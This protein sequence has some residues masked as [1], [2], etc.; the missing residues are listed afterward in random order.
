MQHHQTCRRSLEVYSDVSNKNTLHDGGS[1]KKGSA[2]AAA[3]NVM[4]YGTVRAEGGE[5]RHISAFYHFYTRVK[6]FGDSR[7]YV[8]FWS[9]LLNT[10]SPSDLKASVQKLQQA[11][12]GLNAYPCT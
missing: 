11:L 6:L 10:R 2:A 4:C 1:C 8:G 5:S 9:K 12:I 3:C 7:V